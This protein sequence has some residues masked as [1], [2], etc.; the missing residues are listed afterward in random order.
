M[1]KGNKDRDYKRGSEKKISRKQ[2]IRKAGYAAFSAAT[3]ML[4]LND[5]AKGQ[6]DTP[7]RPEAPPSFEDDFGGW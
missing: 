3:M 1:K 5:P 2:A 7:S 4:L 6:G